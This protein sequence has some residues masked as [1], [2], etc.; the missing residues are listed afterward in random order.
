MWR[1]FFLAIGISVGILGGECLVVD[2]A[3]VSLPRQRNETN[4]LGFPTAQRSK[5]V[6]PPEWAPWSL[7]SAGTVISLYAITL[8]RE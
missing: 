7:L 6:Q 5:A 1:P 8:N 4:A 2:T 3:V